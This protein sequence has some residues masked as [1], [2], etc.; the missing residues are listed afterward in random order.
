MEML[1]ERLRKY[2]DESIDE[3]RYPTYI[4]EIEE[5]DSISN[6]ELAERDLFLAW[7]DEIEKFYIPKELDDEGKPWNMYDN[8]LVFGK[9]G[10]VSGFDG[11]G[12]INILNCDNVT[13]KFAWI[14]VEDVKRPIIKDRD[15]KVINIE[16]EVWDINRIKQGKLIVLKLNIEIGYVLCKTEDNNEV[17]CSGNCLT[18][19]NPI[20]DAEPD[21]LEKIRDDIDAALKGMKVW[22]AQEYVDR[23][24][25][26]I[27][28]SA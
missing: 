18:H 25:A 13:N 28:R 23:L 10:S 15:N 20:H 19:K 21:S 24:T 11:N 2:V 14:S 16:D 17:W 27:E 7:A 9:T 1:H 26:I 12:F 6:D 4:A 5:L 8:C 22:E 3:S